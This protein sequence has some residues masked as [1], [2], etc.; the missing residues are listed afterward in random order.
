MAMHSSVMQMVAGSR[1]VSVATHEVGYE[2]HSSA[3]ETSCAEAPLVEVNMATHGT[4]T[5]RGRRSH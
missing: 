5:F 3:L 2:A 1:P 4:V